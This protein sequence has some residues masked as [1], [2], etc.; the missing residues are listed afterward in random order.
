MNRTIELV[1]IIMATVLLSVSFQPVV[2]ASDINTTTES[3]QIPSIPLA[4]LGAVVGGLLGAVPGL[5][6]GGIPGGGLLGLIGLIF[7]AIFAIICVV[8]AALIGAIGGGGILCT[9]GSLG[10][11]GL[12]G[13]VGAVFGGVMGFVFWP[14]LPLILPC[15]VGIA[16]LLPLWGIEGICAIVAT[17]AAN[18]IVEI[19]SFCVF[20]CVELLFMAIAAIIGIIGWFAALLLWFI[21]LPLGFCALCPCCWPWNLVIISGLVLALLVIFSPTG[22]CMACAILELIFFTAL[23]PI[24]GIAVP[25]L[26]TI[27][28]IG[29]NFWIA[30]GP[31]ILAFIDSLVIFYW[32][33]I[34][35]T[36]I[37][38]IIGFIIPPHDPLTACIGAVIGLFV[39][40]LAMR[41]CYDPCVSTIASALLGGGLGANVVGCLS[42]TIGTIGGGCLLGAAGLIVGAMVL[43]GSIVLSAPIGFV[44]G[45]GVM[46]AILG[47]VL[48]MV[49][50]TGCGCVGLVFDLLLGAAES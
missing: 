1:A 9:V 31:V 50:L 5:I 34:V 14:M 13:L 41:W 3:Q 43:C 4:L 36:I 10:G 39:G 45:G 32:V 47:I 25:G 7:G 46:A 49:G 29:P 18:L 2:I 17:Y 21:T 6:V 24:A 28:L 42:A 23:A 22:C 40:L 26:C 33:P 44:I 12:L 48:A 20:G 38:V 19:I 27:P 15:G 16:I 37:G 8:G 11:G 35:S 30:L